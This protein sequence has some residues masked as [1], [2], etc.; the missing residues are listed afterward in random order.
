MSDVKYT[1]GKIA[2]FGYEDFKG[3]DTF[4]LVLQNEQGQNM[5]PVRGKGLEEAF[6][7]VDNLKKGDSVNLKDMGIDEV[8]K[9]RM[10]EVERHEPYQN[11]ENAIERD[12]ERELQKTPT[13]EKT[14]ENDEPVKLQKPKLAEFEA[15]LPDSIKNNYVAVFK[16]RFLQDEK[17]N[18]YDKSD[19]DKV[20]IAFEDRKNGL[21]TSR[22]D[23]KT[24]KA[25]MDLTESKGWTAIKLKGTEEFKQKAWLEAS[26]RGIETK[27]YEP[28]EKDKAELIAKQEARTVNQVEATAVKEPVLTIKEQLEIETHTQNVPMEKAKINL[29]DVF[30]P[31][32]NRDENGN[33]I[34]KELD[35]L[36]HEA[37]VNHMVQQVEENQR[38]NNKS[39]KDIKAEIRE[40]TQNGYKA[41]IITN[42][43]DLVNTLTDH[44]YEVIKENEK[45]I[46]LKIPN[47]DQHLTLKG[48]MFTKDF[49]ALK[50]LKASLDP[51]AIKERYPQI[52]DV[53]IA[54]ITAWK[55]HIMGKY[56][57]PQAQQEILHRLDS[58]VKDVAN[59][60]DLGMPPIPANEIKPDIDVQINTGDKSRSR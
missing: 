53:G 18:Y 13:V 43:N 9:K 20:N 1:Q 14:K 41:G 58:S 39:D 34:D 3:K 11:L 23:E 15:G 42:R 28:T 12:V 2:D 19:P 32:F 10:W 48:E 7:Q 31:N 55:D 60:K 33:V 49:D 40:I 59:G 45:S 17:I 57:T 38:T 37:M 27:G 36:H 6:K 52:S 25:M 50:Q 5:P 56:T 4:Y 26:L 8:T 30:N 51:E 46:R 35:D 16:N 44:G 22:Q 21:H 29:D 54:Q 24:I 47:S